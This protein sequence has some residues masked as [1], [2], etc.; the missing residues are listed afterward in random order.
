MRGDLQITRSWPARL[1]A[2][3]DAATR[4]GFIGAALCLGVIT[5]SYCYEVVSRYFFSA[6][7]IWASALVSYALC[8]MVFLTVPELARQRAHIVISLLSDSM[9]NHSAA[10]LRR[11]VCMVAGVVCMIAAWF[12]GRATVSQY[13]LDIQTITAWPILKWPLSAFIVYGMFSTSIHF[14]RQVVNDAPVE[15]SL[16]AVS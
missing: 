14:F 13:E 7:T 12:G 3:H 16:A 1:A 2:A 15:S 5:C 4:A 9:S 10:V 6:P 11:V 8:A